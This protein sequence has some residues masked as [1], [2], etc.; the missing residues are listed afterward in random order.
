M[1]ELTLHHIHH[2][3][4]DVDAAVAFYR[5]NFGGEVTERTE[6]AGVQWARVK[7][8]GVMLNI[9]DRGKTDVAL[10]TYNGL[11]HFGLHTSD[12]DETIAALKANGVRFFAE[13]MSPSP[14]VRIA[15]VAGPDNVKI[16]ILQVT[17]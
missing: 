2:E 5:D 10:V 3:A 15:F 13:P 6:R 1:P 14:G 11:D 17:R 4:D 8:G 9:T 12:F 16:E 7:L